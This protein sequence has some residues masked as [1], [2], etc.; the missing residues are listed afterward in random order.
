MMVDMKSSLDE[1]EIFPGEG[2][3]PDSAPTLRKM[4]VMVVEE[5]AQ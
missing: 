4:G 5:I 3:T 1:R 2:E